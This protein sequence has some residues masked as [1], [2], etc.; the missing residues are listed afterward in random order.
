MLYCLTPRPYCAVWQS[1]A[2]QKIRVWVGEY[3]K[4]LSSAVSSTVK[5][6]ATIEIEKYN[7]GLLNMTGG[8]V[9]EH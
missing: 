5:K 2:T 4:G 9:A 1:L 8:W 3:I 6:S 7:F